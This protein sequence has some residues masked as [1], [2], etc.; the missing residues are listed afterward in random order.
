MGGGGRAGR[1]RE[2]EEEDEELGEG[3]SLLA[4]DVSPKECVALNGKVR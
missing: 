2:Q 4:L 1:G 3:G